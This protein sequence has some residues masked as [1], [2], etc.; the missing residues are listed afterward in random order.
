MLD[1]HLPPPTRYQSSRFKLTP[2]GHR[3]SLNEPILLCALVATKLGRNLTKKINSNPE[4]RYFRVLKCPI[5]VE[6]HQTVSWSDPSHAKFSSKIIHVIV[7][8]SSL[9]N[10]PTSLTLQLRC[11]WSLKCTDD[12]KHRAVRYP[13]TIVCS[14]GHHFGSSRHPHHH[15]RMKVHQN[16]WFPMSPCSRFRMR[17]VTIHWHC[18]LQFGPF[19]CLLG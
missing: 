2:S 16:R 14:T 11:P 9:S 17:Q 6:C 19:H 5:S 18:R 15:Y 1:E 3:H 10:H 7:T 8:N 4:T 12:S 13:Y